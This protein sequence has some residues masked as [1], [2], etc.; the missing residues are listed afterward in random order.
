MN[1]LL[2]SLNLWLAVKMFRREDTLTEFYEDLIEHIRMNIGIK[3]FLNSKQETARRRKAN[4]LA[5]YKTMA[6][7]TV[8]GDELSVAG[9]GFLP[10]ANI[11]MIQAGERV[12]RVAD[13]L[14]TALF[15]NKSASKMRSII[16][17]ALFKPVLFF[18][19]AFGLMILF[20]TSVVPQFLTIMPL[21]HVPSSLRLSFKMTQFLLNYAWVV[22]PGG[23]ALIAGTVWSLDNLVGPARRY[24]D[25]IPPFSIYKHVR[26]SSVLITLSG[27]IRNNVTL[28]DAFNVM[29]QNATPY[30][31]SH[32]KPI[33]ARLNQGQRLTKAL[34]T[35]LLPQAIVDRL[36]SFEEAGSNHLE[37]DMSTMGFENVDRSLKS[38]ERGVKAS[39]QVVF[40]LSG[41]ILGWLAFDLLT[42]APAMQQSIQSMQAM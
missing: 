12:N 11:I 20:G 10:T 32:L 41:S 18:F 23:C 24:L 13:G 28:Q 40:I 9:R 39:A 15:A 1:D 35:G 29:I 25:V 36:A 31:R 2:Q 37:T 14:A 3:Q 8:A 34:D 38:V 22:I 42:L 19:M 4:D 26:A 21:E 33:R 27:L 16:V 6:N 30:E 7:R 17:G 5:I